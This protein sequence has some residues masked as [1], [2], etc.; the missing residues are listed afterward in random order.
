MDLSLEREQTLI[1]KTLAR[2]KDNLKSEIGNSGLIQET[3]NRVSAKLNSRLNQAKQYVENIF[4]RVSARFGFG[5]D[6]KNTEEKVHSALKISKKCKK[7]K[8]VIF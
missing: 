8:C 4:T 5:D 3:L 1:Q 2:V 6:N 7:Q